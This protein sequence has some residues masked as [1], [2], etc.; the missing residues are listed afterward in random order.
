MMH[1]TLKREGLFGKSVEVV[2]T[3]GSTARERGL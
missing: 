1:S 3:V 2:M